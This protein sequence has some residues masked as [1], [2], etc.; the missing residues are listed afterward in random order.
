MGILSSILGGSSGES[1]GPGGS[2]DT[3][4]LR[5]QVKQVEQEIESLINL[6][7]EKDELYDGNISNVQSPSAL[8]D[9]AESYRREVLNPVEEKESKISAQ[10]STIEG[11]LENLDQKG[12]YDENVRFAKKNL[13]L[14]EEVLRLLGEHTEE[15]NELV[16]EV[17]EKASQDIDAAKG[18]LH[19]L[20]NKDEKK[21]EEY[22]N[23]LH[24]RWYSL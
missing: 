17:E 20:F 22:R 3:E 19:E 9:L 23:I 5:D 21:L 15:M 2:D 14:L 24:E 4:G 6:V 16:K 18:A 10:E 12:V 11:E 13:A 7:E 1:G 8:L